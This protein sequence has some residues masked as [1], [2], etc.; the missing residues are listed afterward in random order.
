MF[1]ISDELKDLIES[2][3]AVVVG[4]AG[5]GN[6]PHVVPAWAPEVGDDRRTLAVYIEAARSRDVLADVAETGTMAV[7][8][9]CVI[10]YRSIQFK[11]RCRGTRM[12]TPEEGAWI[13]KHFELFRSA[14]AL[15]GDPP[16]TIR[17]MRM[18]DAMRRFELDV[19]SAFDQTP[20]PDAGK[21]L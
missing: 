7:T 18:T 5:A 4:T 16:G 2:G 3:V 9:G 14:T 8:I 13:E 15:V 1:K 6:R 21:Q 19:A 17:N 10:T 20:G 12:A 11:G